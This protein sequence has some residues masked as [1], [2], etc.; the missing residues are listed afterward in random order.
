MTS[1]PASKPDLEAL[2]GLGSCVH[3]AVTTPTDVSLRRYRE[4]AEAGQRHPA[5]ND[6]QFATEMESGSKDISI[7]RMDLP[8]PCLEVDACDGWT[9]G[10]AEIA[11]F[12]S[13]HR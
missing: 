5:H 9:P 7:Y 13:C 1:R 6:L 2:A 3:I 11:D 8:V 4:R 12:I 10:L